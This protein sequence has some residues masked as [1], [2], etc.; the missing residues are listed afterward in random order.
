MLDIKDLSPS[1]AV[2][3]FGVLAVQALLLPRVQFSQGPGHGDRKWGGTLTMYGHTIVEPNVFDVQSEAK[4]T[5][6]RAALKRLMSQFPEWSVP[7][8]PE[9]FPARRCTGW[10]WVEVLQGE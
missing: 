5:L 10:N 3:Y 4:A 2:F 8:E 1:Q 6:C 9:D 7:D